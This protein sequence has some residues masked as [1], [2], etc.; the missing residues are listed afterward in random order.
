MKYHLDL[1]TPETWEAFRENGAT[2][3]GFEMK[4][5]RLA[6]GRV[7]R[8]DI[9]LCYLKGLSRWCGALEVETGPFFDDSPRLG[10]PDPF[11]VRFKVK[12]IVVLTPELA[13]PMQEQRV[14]QALSITKDGKS[15]SWFVR[16]PLI[17]FKDDDGD[18]LLELLKEQQAHP[19]N[20][21]LSKEG[22]ESRE[23]TRYQA[24]VAQIGATMGFRIWVPKN[25]KARVLEQVPCTIHEMFLDKLPLNYNG[26][27]L[28]TIEQI[29]VLWLNDLAMARAFEIE[30]TTA[31]Y[32]GLLRM[33]DLL[34][35]QPN[36]DI[37]MHIAA[38]SYRRE[39][40]FHEVKRPVFSQLKRGPLRDQCSFL[41]YDKIDSLAQNEDLSHMNDSIIEKHAEYAEAAEV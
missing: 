33:A 37:R 25:D 4:H 11:T 1:S 31:I 22:K 12:P 35:L 18:F 38:P 40:V 36:M 16:R 3:T 10:N 8:G 19:T 7:S 5:R 17:T 14:R 20:Y 24:K 13:V 34:A 21:P 41:P 39:Q 32:S 9:F 26:T 6:E 2:V 30:H 23:S 15:W 28:R 29:D 27:T